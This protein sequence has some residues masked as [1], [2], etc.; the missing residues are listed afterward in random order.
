M[1]ERLS[2]LGVC[3]SSSLCAWVSVNIITIGTSVS[4]RS[5]YKLKVSFESSVLDAKC[6]SDLGVCQSSPLCAIVSLR[7]HHKVLQ[8][9]SELTTWCFSICQCLILLWM[10]ECLSTVITI[11]A[12]VSV[13]SHYCRCRVSQS[14]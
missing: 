2:D 7:A 13:R 12:W 14:S 5:H 11:G 4:F 3:Q 1:L 10:L 6:L 8:C 9:L